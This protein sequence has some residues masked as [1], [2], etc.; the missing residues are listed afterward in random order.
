LGFIAYDLSALV[1]DEIKTG[2][3]NHKENLAALGA[4]AIGTAIP[5][6]TGAGL[7]VRV[8]SKIDHIADVAKAIESVK[9]GKVS[10]TTTQKMQMNPLDLT[11]THPLTMSRKEFLRLKSDI[12]LNGIQETIKYVEEQ[13]RKY[14]VDGHHRTQV[15]KE[16]GSK[17]VPSQQVQ[18]PF[19]DYKSVHDL[20]HFGN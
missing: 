18:L 9:N 20:Y 19:A 1:A 15:A 4:D 12:K 6:V 17:T 13:G 11:P 14:I 16:L 10:I 7:A 2:G 5:F 3:E 8:G